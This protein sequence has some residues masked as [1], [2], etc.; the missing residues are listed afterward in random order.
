MCIPHCLYAFI[1]GGHL[2]SL[3]IL[4]TVDNATINMRMPICLKDNDFILFGYIP[5]RGIDRPY[6]IYIFNFLRKF[7]TVFHSGCF[8]LHSYK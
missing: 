3:H 1:L 5:R 7:C 8:N 4:A 6:V 2:G